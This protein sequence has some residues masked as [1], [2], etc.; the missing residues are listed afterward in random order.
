MLG[1]FPQLGDIAIE[2]AWGGFVDLTMNQ[3]PAFG[4]L[5]PNIFYL[6]GF[7]GHGLALTGM[8]GKLVAETIAGQAERFDLFTRI[9]HL[10]FPGGKH[11]RT[12]ALILG[13][14]Y[15]RLRDML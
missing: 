1:V 11:L 7:S 2:Y 9:R 12:P 8:A 5:Q 10:P 4:R 3:A 15:Y 14:W 13:M 6:H